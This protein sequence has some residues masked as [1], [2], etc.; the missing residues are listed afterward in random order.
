MPESIRKHAQRAQ[1]R[2][3]LIEVFH[4]VEEV[5]LGGRVELGR[6]L[7]LDQHLQEEGEEIEVFL[8]RRERKRVDL[9]IP[10][11]Q[12]DADI[13]AAEKLREILKAS[14]QVE[15][16][17]VRRV[18][19]QISNQEVQK[20]TLTGTRSSQNHGVGHIAVMEI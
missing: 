1:R 9:E 2:V 8:G 18:L 10:G 20:K 5:A 14:A 4:L 7:P 13:Q 11:F 6:P 19:L 12:A 15:D 16:E 17:H 3:H